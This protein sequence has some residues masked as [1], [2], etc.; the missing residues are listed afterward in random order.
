[1]NR[2]DLFVFIDQHLLPNGNPCPMKHKYKNRREEV[3]ANMDKQIKK[4]F[5]P[6]P[7]PKKGESGY[8]GKFVSCYSMH[9]ACLVYHCPRWSS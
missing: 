1:L 2:I 4:P 3:E 6:A 5:V 9:T 8:F 7:P